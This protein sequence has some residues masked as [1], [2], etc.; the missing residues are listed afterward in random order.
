VATA[1]AG[2]VVQVREAERAHAAPGPHP[3][4]D[5]PLRAPEFVGREQELQAL[6]SALRRGQHQALSAAV[7]GMGGV[8]KSALAAEALARLAV[9]Q[10]PV[11]PGGITWMRCDGRSGLDGLAWVFDRL[12]DAWDVPPPGVSSRAPENPDESVRRRARALSAHLRPAD[13]SGVAKPAPALVLLDNVEV[14]LPLATALETLSPLGV[15]VLVTARHQPSIPGLR[16]V[17]LEVLELEAALHLFAQRYADHGGAWDPDRDAAPA[18]AAVEMLGRLPLAIELAAARAALAHMSVATL[19][20]ELAQPTVLNL[21]R[22]PLKPAASVRYS[23]ERSLT[24]LIPAQRAGF[25]ALGLPDGPDWPRLVVEHLQSA[26]S[27]ATAVTT[28]SDADEDVERLAALSLVGLSTSGAGAGSRVRLH[29]LLRALAKEEWERQPQ[30]TRWAGLTGL[31]SGVAEGIRSHTV[32]AQ[33]DRA[34]L[35]GAFMSARHLDVDPRHTFLIASALSL[36]DSMIWTEGEF[37]QMLSNALVAFHADGDKISEAAVWSMKGCRAV[38]HH[39]SREIAQYTSQAVNLLR[40][41]G[42][43]AGAA[44]AWRDVAWRCVVWGLEGDGRY[45]YIKALLLYREL[46]DRVTQGRI[47]NELAKLEDER[48]NSDLADRNREEAA[49][50]FKETGQSS[51]P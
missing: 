29:P 49:A 26:V 40:A 11:F 4:H 35:T 42:D 51:D 14:D 2:Y 25:A 3:P 48:G 10:P 8:G 16:L 28:T 24:L 6:C 50:I 38:P 44:D 37:E 30:P 19:A 32:S 20:G 23:F 39:K 45:Y 47:L 36:A 43:L 22:D 9:E 7:A 21:L 17:A 5:L 41:V 33:T 18:Q 27:T 46:G 31:L 1:L 15:T 34:L 12:L 13:R